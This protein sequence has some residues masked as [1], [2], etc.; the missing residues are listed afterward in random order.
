[1][2]PKQKDRR[3]VLSAVLL[4]YTCQKPSAGRT[5][6]GSRTATDALLQLVIFHLHF[7]KAG[8]QKCK[9]DR[10]WMREQHAKSAYCLRE[11]FIF[12]QKM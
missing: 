9:A 11:I 2:L 8:G 6:N 3:K 7:C 1:M 10:I 12:T 5:E 4:L